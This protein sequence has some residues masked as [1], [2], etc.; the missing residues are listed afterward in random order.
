MKRLLS[1]FQYKLTV[2]GENA[3]DVV[4]QLNQ[5]LPESY[6]EENTTEINLNDLDALYTATR[7]VK[8]VGLSW[9]LDCIPWT[10]AWLSEKMFGSI[11]L[12][13]DTVFTAITTIVVLFTM[14]L[15]FTLVVAKLI[16]P[17]HTVEIL[18]YFKL[19]QSK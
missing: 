7:S 4:K 3:V 1:K 2:S 11:S 15:A 8:S 12:Y 9:Q 19:P 18:K 5:L 16:E 10:R 6:W 17:T 14:Q 13:P